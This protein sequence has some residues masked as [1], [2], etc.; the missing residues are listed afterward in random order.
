MAARCGASK[1]NL[2]ELSIV[3]PFE[4]LAAAS[5]IKYSLILCGILA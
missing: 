5:I 4:T 2:P 3:T 1:A